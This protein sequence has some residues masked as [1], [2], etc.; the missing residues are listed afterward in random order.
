[1]TVKLNIT[2]VGN[3]KGVSMSGLLAEVLK[4]VNGS[5]LKYQVTSTGTI[6]EGSW[7]QVFSLVERYQE[8]VKHRIGPVITHITIDDQIRKK[9]LREDEA[10]VMEKKMERELRTCGYQPV[11][12]EYCP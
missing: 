1:M 11:H 5:S 4:V 6:L 12:G 9:E 2:P 3:L 8:V 10:V 7:Q